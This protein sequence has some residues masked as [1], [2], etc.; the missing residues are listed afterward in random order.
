VHILTPFNWSVKCIYI[1]ILT[2]LAIFFSEVLV[3]ILL[4][5]YFDVLYMM[6]A[7]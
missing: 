7:I 1:Y 6:S 5:D 2:Y 3:S 4:L